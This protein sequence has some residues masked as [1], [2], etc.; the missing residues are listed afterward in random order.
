[1]DPRL[2]KTLMN[3]P[4]E[5]G[6][7]ALPGRR[8]RSRS[9]SAGK[10]KAAAAAAAPANNGMTHSEFVAMMMARKMKKM[11]Q[12]FTNPKKG[13]VIWDIEDPENTEKHLMWD[14][15]DWVQ[16]V[17]IFGDYG[18][19]PANARD[20]VAMRGLLAHPV[21]RADMREFAPADL[22]DTIFTETL[23]MVP[24]AR[25]AEAAADG[26]PKYKAALVSAAASDPTLMT[27]KI[28]LA[29]K[30]RRALKEF[31]PADAAPPQRQKKAKGGGRTHRARKGR[32]SSRKGTRRH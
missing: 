5:W 1:M 22:D 13:T 16:A 18:V 11:M 4:S 26:L 32:R 6:R 8:S 30:A 20:P 7:V 19:G 29:A 9:R 21:Y 3:M 28:K 31:L 14:G 24:A 12:R 27:D 23:A 25:R 15:H 10:G 17:D 2:A